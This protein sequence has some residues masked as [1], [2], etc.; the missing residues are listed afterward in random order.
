M[1]L[2]VNLDI[3]FRLLWRHVFTVEVIKAHFNIKTEEDKATFLSWVGNLFTDKKHIRVVEY[4]DKCGKSF[5]EDTEYRV[6]EVTSRLESDLQ[7]SLGSTAFGVGGSIKAGE[8]LTREEK[9]DVI[10]RAQTVVNAVQIRELSEIIELLRDILA[11]NPQKNYYITI[12]RLD[13]DWVEDRLRYLLIRALIETVRDFSQAQQVKI[14]VALRYDL[15]DRVIRLTRSAGFQQEKYES[16]NLHLQWSREQLVSV[17]DSRIERLVEQ[18]YTKQKVTHKDILPNSIQK[19]KGTIEYILERTFMRPRDIIH[20]FN[21]CILQAN[22]Q[23]QITGQMVRQAEREYSTDRLKALAEEWIV[24][25]PGLLMFKEVLKSRPPRFKVQDVTVRDC[26]ELC[27]AI[28]ASSS[29]RN[30]E[31][32]DMAYRVVEVSFPV[33]EFRQNLMQCFYR[34]GLVGLKLGASEKVYW[35]TSGP[36]RSVSV[37]EIAAD[38]GVAVHPCFW[39]V[40]GIRH[41]ADAEVGVE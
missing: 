6:R 18:R 13:E 16:L 23:P 10:K 7:S 24:D 40:L 14:V 28:A 20:F 12:D 29:S 22:N 39:R 1:D 32:E 2:G 36:R 25:Y 4:L 26:E 35:S 5:W 27:L 3:F 38:S 33:G 37:A 9:A 11:K 8:H 34:V 19:N 41:D 15:F 30:G 21:L 31:L 17:L